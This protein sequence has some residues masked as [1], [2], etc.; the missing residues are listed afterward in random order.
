VESL[1]R[2]LLVAAIRDTVPL[3]TTSLDSQLHLLKEQTCNVIVLM[4]PLPVQLYDLDQ[5]QAVAMNEVALQLADESSDLIQSPL[6]DPLVIGR[7]L[8]S[9]DRCPEAKGLIRTHHQLKFR[10]LSG[11]EPG[12]KPDP[13]FAE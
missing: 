5:A 4:V 3:G 12:G 8:P 9:E 7:I 11:Q 13:Q 1:A 2:S 6:L 10:T